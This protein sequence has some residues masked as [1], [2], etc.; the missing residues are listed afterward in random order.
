MK[1]TALRIWQRTA[2]FAVI[3]AV[4]VVLFAVST[5]A[6]Q[7][8]DDKTK[9]TSKD[10]KTGQSA[11]QSTASAVQNYGADTS[12][13]PGTIVRLADKTGTK[14]APAQ[15]S[16]P[17]EIYGLV[18]PATN[19]SITVTSSDLP[20]PVFVGTSGAYNALVST[21]G[22][23]IKAGDYITVSSIDGVGRLAAPGEKVTV[24][25]RATADFDGKSNTLGSVQ[26]KTKG[27]GDGQKVALGSISLVIDIKDNPQE[28]STKANVPPFLEKLGEEIA[29]K[30]VSPIRIYLSIAITGITVVVALVLLYAGVRNAVIAIGRN[31]LSKKT[32]V[33]TLVEIILAGFIILIIGLF[34]VYLLLKL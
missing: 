32:I 27:G 22:G 10:A 7:A 30:Q 12:L 28:K 3:M 25:G 8:Q 13:Q 2:S 21:E 17:K 23:T 19:L 18:V 15:S 16:N 4:F 6:V 5:T 11:A 26:L 33:R 9:D 1:T 31:P 24:A 14:V 29:D 34:T 20:N